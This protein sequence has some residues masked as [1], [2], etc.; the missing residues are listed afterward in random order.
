MYSSERPTRASSLELAA[1]AE[2]VSSWTIGRATKISGRN[3]IV[4]IT[5]RL[6]R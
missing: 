2:T 6:R 3:A 5:K 4:P 1:A